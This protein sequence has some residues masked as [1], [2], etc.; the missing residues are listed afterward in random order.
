LTTFEDV[1]KIIAEET[2]EDDIAP[3][4]KLMDLAD[5]LELAAL[6][7]EL[8]H[9]L[10]VEIPEHDAQKLFTVQDVVNYVNSRSIVV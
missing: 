10:G 8:E 9:E 3:A 4:T 7:L 6:L 5:S 2:G 1:R